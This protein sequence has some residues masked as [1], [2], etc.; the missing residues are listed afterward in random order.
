[1]FHKLF[2]GKIYFT[3]PISF[4]I[5]K[6]GELLKNHFS[7]RKPEQNFEDL[8]Y[9]VVMP[10][11]HS[12]DKTEKNAK[13]FY[14]EHQKIYEYLHQKNYDVHYLF[15]PRDKEYINNYSNVINHHEIKELEENRVC[16]VSVWSSLCLNRRYGGK[17][18]FWCKSSK[19]SEI[20][21]LSPSLVH[22]IQPI[23]K[24]IY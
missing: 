18:G 22:E 16:Y 14:Q 9:I 15:H 20:Q 2:K 4:N 7:F 1:M 24:I 12:H 21:Q 23:N 13:N 8:I 5:S 17:Y 3:D 6:K 10:A 11:A 19:D